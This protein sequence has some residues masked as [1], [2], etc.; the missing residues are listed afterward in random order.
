MTLAKHW[1]TGARA[2][3]VSK[4]SRLKEEKKKKKKKKNV[5]FLSPYYPQF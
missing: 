3:L 1:Q 2:M 4:P 5:F